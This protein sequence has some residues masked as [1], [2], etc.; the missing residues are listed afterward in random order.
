MGFIR[1]NKNPLNKSVDD[2]VVRAITTA[3]G[4]SWNKVYLDLALDGYIE[5]DMPNGNMIWESYLFSHGFSRHVI[6]DT[7][8]LCYTVRQ[9]ASDHR[10][11]IYIVG[12]GTHAVAVVDGF[13]ID[14]WDSGDRTVLFYFRKDE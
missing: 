1:D 11:G 10:H 3:T 13:Y 4:Q 14:T 8:P 6:P 7:C 5:K 12:D 2:C 9:F